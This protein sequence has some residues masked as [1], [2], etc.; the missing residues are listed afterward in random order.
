MA[1]KF[2]EKQMNKNYH[3]ELMRVCKVCLKPETGE[4]CSHCGSDEFTGTFKI[5]TVNRWGL[6][7][8]FKAAHPE[9]TNVKPWDINLKG[10]CTVTEY[11]YIR[12]NGTSGSSGYLRWGGNTNRHGEKQWKQSWKSCF[13]T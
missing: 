10:E 4:K 8:K 12:Y 11:G 2:L 3:H 6:Y 1:N 9:R 13:N 5:Y 7:M